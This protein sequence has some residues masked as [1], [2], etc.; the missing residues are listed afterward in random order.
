VREGGDAGAA[1][2]L[3]AYARARADDR[4]RTLALSDGLARLTAR[5]GL[6]AQV[7]RALGFGLLG[8]V[9]DLRAPLVAGAM[10]YAGRLASPA[11][12]G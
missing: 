10:G 5:G 11:G 7:L 4:A 9:P 2:G 6:P 12:R 1:A 8:A 3:E